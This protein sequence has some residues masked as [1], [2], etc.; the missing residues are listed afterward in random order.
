MSI[1]TPTL[2]LL[3]L[4][5]AL[6]THVDSA[7]LNSTSSCLDKC[8]SIPIKYPLG[9]GFGCGHPEFSPYV[10]CTDDGATLQLSTRSGLYT[11]SAVDYSSSTLTLS[12]PL[13]STCASM[14][15]SGSFTL[16]PT[17][18][19]HLVPHDVFVVLGCSTSSPVFDSDVQLCDP[20][21]SHVCRGLYSCKGVVGLGLTPGDPVSTCC[22]YDPPGGVG[23]GR[24]YS[25]DLP[26][27]QCASYTCLHGFGE[28]E[29][30]P[31]KWKYGIELS[32]NDSYGT[33][34]C[35]ACE[36]SVGTCGFEGADESFVCVCRN[37]VN[38]TTNCYGQGY[39]WSG[40][41]KQDQEK[42]MQM[43]T[44]GILLLLIVLLQS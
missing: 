22:V 28:K 21:A 31:T 11:I 3:L 36:S 17:V 10:R 30:D 9:T 39:T 13:M 1:S 20:G 23:T 7:F 15:N 44:L 25:L 33:D 2:F 34:A 43:H 35:D 27:L 6:C 26:K 37:G 4:A 42:K 14:Q 24:G 40:S 12:D 16:D 29:G 32:F 5:A 19:F 41:W 8:G 38:T 18:P